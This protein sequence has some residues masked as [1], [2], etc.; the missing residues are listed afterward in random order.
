MYTRIRDNLISPKNLYQRRYDKAGITVLFFFLLAI[1]LSISSIVDIVRYDGLTA[2]NKSEIKMLLADQMDIPCTIDYGLFCETDEL[3]KITY[4][5]I[6]V[7][8]DPTGEFI[9]GDLGVNVVLQEDT[10]TLYSASQVL[11]V[12]DYANTTSS[13]IPWPSDWAQLSFDGSDIFWSDFFLGLDGM[14]DDYRGMWIPMSIA[15]TIVTVSVLLFSE[16]LIDTL[17]LSIFR[18]GGLKYGEMFK[19]VVNAATAYVLVSVILDLYS[20]DIGYL[21]R[22]LLQIIPVVYVLLSIRSQRGELDV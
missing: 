8:V 13:A 18:Y 14:I 5:N 9:P 3:H 1:L 20:L 17:I 10:V 12:T 6:N 7:F 16:L 2:N 22:S 19:L 21:T 11:S 4:A 15:F